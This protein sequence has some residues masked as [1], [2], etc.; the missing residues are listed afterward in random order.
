LDFVPKLPIY[1]STLQLRCRVTESS[2]YTSQPYMIFT[3]H[4]ADFQP[5]PFYSVV[6]FSDGFV[7][8]VYQVVCYYINSNL[9]RLS[10]QMQF[11][12][13]EQPTAVTIQAV[14]DKS[15]KD[16]YA[17][18]LQCKPN[19]YPP[20]VLNTEW[21]VLTGP[22]F[23]FVQ[24]GKEFALTKFATYGYYLVYCDALVAFGATTKHFNTTRRFLYSVDEFDDFIVYDTQCLARK[25]G[26]QFR[27]IVRNFDT[28]QQ[29]LQQ[30][31]LLR[32]TSIRETNGKV[33][34]VKARADRYRRRR[35]GAH[36]RRR[37]KQIAEKSSHE[38]KV[39]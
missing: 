15:E 5:L 28:I 34:Q 2:R 12:F 23:A 14:T 21:A 25:T 38:N 36:G 17:V 20:E 6:D 37:M 10:K 30:T 22:K 24:K 11:S 16:S 33:E 18:R 13:H 8:G 35:M 19:G 9:V 29:I 39:D 1:K 4:P 7:G 27:A 32:K 31:I 3:E 26:S